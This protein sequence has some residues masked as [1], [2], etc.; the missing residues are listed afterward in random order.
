MFR[1]D[2]ND[3]TDKITCTFHRVEFV[4]P[5]PSFEWESNPTY[6]TLNIDDNL[7][8][9]IKVSVPGGIQSITMTVESE[10]LKSEMADEYGIRSGR[11]ILTEGSNLAAETYLNTVC[12]DDI[13]FESDLVGQTEITIDLTAYVKL[14]NDL[15]NK[16]SDHKV[17]F[18]V[19]DNEDQTA[20]RN[21][22]STE[23]LL[24]DR[25]L[26]GNPILISPR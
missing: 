10:A 16:E 25:K 19:I 6:E 15:T 11:I 4:I 1:W 18:V 7:D 13:P 3:K 21:L 17:G 26:Y 23:S 24:P 20:L 8:A 5:I 14:I 12:G 22:H 9:V 2:N